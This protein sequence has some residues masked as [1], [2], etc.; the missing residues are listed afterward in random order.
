MMLT[1]RAVQEYLVCEGYSWNMCAS[2]DCSD[3][4]PHT[5]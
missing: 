3:A 2:S 4:D 1:R 5:V